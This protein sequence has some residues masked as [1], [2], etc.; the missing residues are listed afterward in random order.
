MLRLFPAALGELFTVLVLAA[1]V[2]L[3]PGEGCTID[4]DA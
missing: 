4:A 2:R 1:T 3:S